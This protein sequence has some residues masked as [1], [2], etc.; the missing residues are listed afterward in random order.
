MILVF[1]QIHL[2]ALEKMNCETNA[3][4]HLPTHL[5]LANATSKFLFLLFLCPVLRHCFP[6]HV[7]QQ[8]SSLYN[9]PLPTYSQTRP[10]TTSPVQQNTKHSSLQPCQLMQEP[11]KKSPC[12][13]CIEKCI[14]GCFVKL[15]LQCGVRNQL[16]VKMSLSIIF[17]SPL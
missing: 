4:T 14:F 9:Q 8:V 10:P 12:H 15:I 2:S 3:H 11:K 7:I 5:N 16:D 1:I 6:C 13:E 17:I